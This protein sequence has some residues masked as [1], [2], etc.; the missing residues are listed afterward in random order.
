MIGWI[1]IYTV[2]AFAFM[3][4]AFMGGNF[5]SSSIRKAIISRE[6]P[7]PAGP[8]PSQPNILAGWAELA[9]KRMPGAGLVILTV[10]MGPDQS[11]ITISPDI[12]RQTARKLLLA[13][14]EAEAAPTTLPEVK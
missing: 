13:A 12:A 6:V 11:T 3:V 14:D 7:V 8:V 2:A 10:T 4:F 5:I 1:V 9:V